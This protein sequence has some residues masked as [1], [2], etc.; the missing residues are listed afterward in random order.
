MSTADSTH[1]F[2][3]LQEIFSTLS[4]SSLRDKAWD[5]F[6]ELG[7]PDKSA[8]AFKYVPL[9][10]LYD[11]KLSIK[12]AAVSKEMIEPYI[13]SEA[14]ESYIVFANGRFCKELSKIPSKLVI[15][16]LQEAL[17]TYGPFLQGRLSKSIK[18]ETDPFAVLN[19]ALQQE[20]VFC[21]LPPKQQLENPLQIIHVGPG[22]SSYHP[23]RLHFFCSRE[24]E[25]KT[26]STIIGD[27][28]HHISMDAALEEQACFSH[29]QTS[30][31]E[32]VLNDFR[33]TL[34]SNATLKH[35]ALT[36]KGLLN[37]NRLKLTLLGDNASALL[38]GLWN[39]SENHQCHTNVHVEHVSPN[40]HSLQKFKGVLQKHSQSSFEGK[41]YVHPEAQKTEA[42]QLNHNLLLSDAAVANAKPN[43]EIF[44]DDVKASHGATMSEVDEEQ[45]FYLQSRGLTKESARTLL[46][47]G[48]IQEMLD[49]IPYASVRDGFHF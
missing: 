43:L 19:L 21:Y 6:L 41:I 45:L 13:L 8:D 2:A 34:K 42:Y 39:L 47:R 15:L 4:S 24:S 3:S 38:Q 31:G 33:A 18:D 36:T 14:L 30:N 46:V 27:G 22:A 23:A 12:A 40:C 32:I 9:K 20:G 28:V 25:L 35:L 7:L 48:F 29:V 11:I 10:R 44:A 5:H 26:I 17:K 37:R 1:F 49:Q 16:P